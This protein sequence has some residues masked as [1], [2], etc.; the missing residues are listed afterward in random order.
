MKANNIIGLIEPNIVIRTYL[1][2]YSL[3]V[4]PHKCFTMLQFCAVLFPNLLS[5]E[6]SNYE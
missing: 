4:F 2:E 1:I 6:I 5:I 3:K